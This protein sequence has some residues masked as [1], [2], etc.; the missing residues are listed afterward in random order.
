MK[1]TFGH[2]LVL[3][4]CTVL[5]LLS[6][7]AAPSAG[8]AGAAP[9]VPP[10]DTVKSL[11]AEAK[12]APQQ[13]ATLSFPTS[14]LIAEVLVKEGDQVKAGQPIAR[15]RNERQAAELTRA[16][17]AL[18][19]AQAQRDTVKAGLREEEIAASEAQLDVMKVLLDRLNEDAPPEDIA[20]TD[21]AVASAEKAQ[22]DLLESPARPEEVR[23][24]DA[25]VKMAE[26]ELA[27]AQ[28]AL[29]DA[30]LV[31]PFAG[32]I[33]SLDA[34]AGEEVAAGAPLAR[35]GDLSAWKVETTNLSEVSLARVQMGQPVTLTFDALPNVQLPGKVTAI[36][37]VGENRQ[38]DTVYAVTVT[39]EGSDPGL[40]WNMTVL[41]TF[42]K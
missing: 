37:G 16:Q 31:A 20:K 40:R 13:S 5:A 35:L 42:G 36:R 1:R 33:V 26:A 21:A 24:A 14:G 23:A 27:Q 38:G 4:V 29:R 12:L 41:V 28:A 9:A 17:A 15:L 10:V 25:S 7:C 6:G 2:L 11:T 8:A 18:D 39:P 3:T 22:H 30:E 32:T 19:R 34:R